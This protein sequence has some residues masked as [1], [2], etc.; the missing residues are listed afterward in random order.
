MANVIVRLPRS[1]VEVLIGA[2][3]GPKACGVERTMLSG[4][5]LLKC[6]RL[7]RLDWGE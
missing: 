6:F 2:G 7:S 5:L 4:P 3:S 1:D